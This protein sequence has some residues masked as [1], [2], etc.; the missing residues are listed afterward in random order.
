MS[1]SPQPERK[2]SVFRRPLRSYSLG[3]QLVLLVVLKMAVLTVLWHALIKPYRVNVKTD[4]MA[5][6]LV[7][8]AGRVQ[9]K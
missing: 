6:Q 1:H 8:P 2:L 3:V 5:H 9:E 7:A 4:A